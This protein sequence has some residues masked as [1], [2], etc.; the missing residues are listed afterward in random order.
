VYSE[1]S[2]LRCWLDYG[3]GGGSGARGP[4]PGP[5]F[6]VLAPDLTCNISRKDTCHSLKLFYA[7]K[8]D[9]RFQRYR[10]LIDIF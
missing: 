2:P 7:F 6:C 9:M 8:V 4:G 1:V 10:S 3:G 5:V